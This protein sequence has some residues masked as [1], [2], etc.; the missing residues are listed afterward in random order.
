MHDAHAIDLKP[1]SRWRSAVCESEI[2]VVRAP[3]APVL[4]C[5]GGAPVLEAGRD[6]PAGRAPDGAL[7]EGTLLGKRYADETSGLELLCTRSGAGTITVAG[8]RATILAPRK[9]PASD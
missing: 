1:G 4:L 9:L 2:I 5:I 7:A 3:A 8:R 6:Q